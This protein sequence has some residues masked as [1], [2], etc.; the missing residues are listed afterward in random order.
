MS[1]GICRTVLRITVLP[2]N[3]SGYTQDH[4]AYNT[5][6]NIITL[7]CDNISL[8]KGGSSVLSEGYGEWPNL[9]A[10][11]G[12]VFGGRRR[13]PLDPRHS[14]R[15]LRNAVSSPDRLKIFRLDALA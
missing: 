11:K 2:N 13:A 3:P 6:L 8:T 10:D 15:C 14:C 4:P 7:P 1:F 5:S 12:A 9:E